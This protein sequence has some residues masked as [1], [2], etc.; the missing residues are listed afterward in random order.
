MKHIEE[1]KTGHLEQLAAYVNTLY[2]KPQL[3]QLFFELTLRCNESCFHC[4]SKCSVV[5][6]PEMTKEEYFRILDQVKEDFDIS[7]LQLCITGGE[8]LLRSDFFEILGYAHTLGYTWGMTTNAT[9]VTAE[10]AARLA[11]AGMK[12]V[13]VSID[14][15]EATHDRLRGLPGG[16]RKAMAGIQHLIDAHAFANVQV[17]TVVNHENIDELDAL[18]DIMQQL[19]IDSWRVIHLEPIG[20]ALDWPERMLTRED[21]LRL[22]AFIKEKRAAGWPVEY[23]CSHY[24]GLA[25]EAEVRDWY[26][27]CNAG[28][29]T[30]SIMA[31]GDIG[32]CLDIERR[33]DTIQGNIRQDRLKDVWENRF[34]LFRRPLSEHTEMCRDCAHARFCRGDAFHSYDYDRQ[35]PYLCMKGILFE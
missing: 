33:P 14:G 29:Y 3:R 21:Y 28:V 16:Y 1:I 32:A 8:P 20:L 19:G 18:A 34:E 15:L 4:G 2:E 5:R 35:K 9:L 25:Y 24:L 12:T 23:G 30:A 6:S 31:N 11:E 13:S 27:Q 10:T 17:T 22:F 7:R 26:W